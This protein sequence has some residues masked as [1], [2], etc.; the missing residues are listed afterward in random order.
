MSGAPTLFANIEWGT[1][2]VALIGLVGVVTAAL[3][4]ARGNHRTDMQAFIDQVQEERNTYAQQLREERAANSDR[5]DALWADKAMS[6]EYVAQLRAHIH[7]G[8]PPPPPPA[9]DG[10]IE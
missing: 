4:T 9:P 5:L 6:R 3:L 10:Y 1:V 2:L 8:S 7:Q